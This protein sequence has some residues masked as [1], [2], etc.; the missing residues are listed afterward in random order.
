LCR[1]ALQQNPRDADALHLL[2]LIAGR[3]GRPDVSAQLLAQASQIRPESGEIHSSLGTALLQLDRLPEAARAYETAITLTPSDFS[4]H[5]NLAVVHQRFGRTREAADSFR[6]AVKL[7]PHHALARLNLATVARDSGALEEADEQFRKAIEIDPNL[8]DAHVGLAWLRLLRGDF[9]RGWQGYEW[10]WRCPGFEWPKFPQ[11]LWDGSNLNGRTI[12]LHAEQG[13]GDTIQFAR[14][15]SLL[16]GQGARVILYCPRVLSSLLATV[17]GIAA[18]ASE[19]RMLPTF[20]VWCP[21]MSLPLKLRT[22]VETIPATV[23]YVSVDPALDATWAARVRADR[24][25]YRVGLCWAGNRANMNDA[26]RSVAPTALVPL[27]SVPGVTF[28]SL[29]VSNELAPAG[30]VDH[31]SHVR[32]FADS[33][34]LVAQLDLVITV[35][36]A[37]AHLAGALGKP[38][39]VMLPFAPDW[40]WMLDRP[41]SPWYPTMRL[42]RKGPCDPWPPMIETVAAELSK[43]LATTPPI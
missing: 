17:P 43:R 3:A 40:R 41:D 12:M 19:Q 36:T 38:V 9:A 42:F 13:L 29:Q 28:H 16:A 2:A 15:A 5:H 32:D 35:D 26:N 37:V 7:A 30:L 8:A 31:T 27:T 39:W 20:D 11:P 18:C 25:G 6:T 23:P 33:A 21:L 1:A 24:P 34:A 10:R 22:T 14:F 4:A